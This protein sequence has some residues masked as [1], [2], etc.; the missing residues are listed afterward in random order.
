MDDQYS[1]IHYGWLDVMSESSASAWSKLS[2]KKPWKKRFI[3]LRQAA[4]NP[5]E[6]QLAAYDKDD[7]WKVVEAK[8]SLMLFPRYRIAKLCNYKGKENCLEVD[9]EK[10]Q[11][12]F[13]S[14]KLKNLDL[15]A[16]QIQMQTKLSRAISG[17][18]FSVSGAVQKDM[19][20]IGAAQQRC[21][22][23]FTKWGITL[24]L[25]D[26]RSILA[27]WPLKTIRNYEESGQC[28]FTIEA[29]RR[30]PMG[31]GLYKFYTNMGQDRDMFNVIDAFVNALLNEQAYT[32]GKNQTTDE[33]IL[34]T[35]EQLHKAA[36]GFYASEPRPRVNDSV[37]TS[38]YS[39]IG[40]MMQK[41]ILRDST[42]LSIHKPPDYHHLYGAD[43]DFTRVQL[44]DEK[45]FSPNNSLKKIESPRGFSFSEDRDGGGNYDKLGGRNQS[46]GATAS[47]P[48][49]Y[50]RIH[51][52]R[53]NHPSQDSVYDK[54]DRSEH[55]ASF[56][57]IS[58][59]MYIYV[60]TYG[61]TESRGASYF[62]FVKEV[63]FKR[64]KLYIYIH[65]AYIEASVCHYHLCCYLELVWLMLRNG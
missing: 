48:G 37:D 59:Y 64:Y 39:H 7:H 6:I 20:R 26:S 21:L 58:Q 53:E 9:N 5:D 24:A 29:G 55:G 10:E 60:Y 44:D 16:S 56:K 3:V 19:Q 27:M 57:V 43:V 11:W 54:I 28:E 36:I 12:H 61:I 65:Q 17:R 8:K 63:V 42:S 62:E 40:D 25:Q 22:L 30:A 49:E 2:G 41:K 35:Y 13:A 34:K 1:I 4:D 46:W 50:D 18:I 47:P 15:W 52:R 45:K 51:H 31:E 14:D 32:S 33:E 23:H 38:G